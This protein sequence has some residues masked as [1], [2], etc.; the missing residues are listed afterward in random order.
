MAPGAAGIAIWHNFDAPETYSIVQTA[1]FFDVDIA[2]GLVTIVEELSANTPYEFMLELKDGTFTATRE[3]RFTTDQIE[4][5]KLVVLNTRRPASDEVIVT[6]GWRPVSGADRYTL[7]R[8]AGSETGEYISKYE[9]AG[10]AVDECALSGGV[11]GGNCNALADWLVF[12]EDDLTLGSVYYYRLDSCGDLGCAESD[13]LSLSVSSPPPPIFDSAPATSPDLELVTLL[14]GAS[15][16]AAIFEWD[17][18]LTSEVVEGRYTVVLSVS[19]N[20]DSGV[21]TTIYDEYDATVTLTNA[22]PYDYRLS[23]SSQGETGDYIEV[24]ESNPFGNARK[25]GYF[26]SDLTLGSVYYYRLSVCN[27]SGCADPSAVVMLPVNL[28]PPG[29][30]APELDVRRFDH[31]DVL[32]SQVITLDSGAT[33]VMFSVHSPAS[34]TVTLTWTQVDRSDKYRVFR[35]TLAAETDEAVIRY[36][37]GRIEYRLLKDLDY[38]EIYEGEGVS[39]HN[40][41]LAHIDAVSQDA[42]YYYQVEACDADDDCGDRSNFVRVGAPPRPLSQTPDGVPNLAITDIDVAVKGDALD[43]VSLTVAD[44]VL[45]WSEVSGAN[46]Y[47]LLRAQIG[48]GYEEIYRGLDLL[49]IESNARIGD[50]YFYRVQACNGLSCGASSEAV[51]LRLRRPGL[52]RILFDQSGSSREVVSAGGTVFALSSV[53]LAWEETPNAQYYYVLRG[54]AHG[55]DPFVTVSH[56][57]TLDGR[58]DTPLP[59][60]ATTYVENLHGDDVRHYRVQACNAFGCGD[61]SNTV[62]LGGG[63]LGIGDDGQWQDGSER[64]G[65]GRCDSHRGDCRFAD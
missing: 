21:S 20:M 38:V 18:L 31:G 47:R 59:V 24:H 54:G 60:F 23:R 2:T 64:R 50:I 1:S 46:N 7:S 45:E 58:A 29:L 65:R 17:V 41:R 37:D 43:V 55:D 40:D 6:L 10:E 35:A 42:V 3:F 9:G 53:T 5:G 36:G 28:D 14:H 16:P 52:A 19:V 56:P 34:L 8:A 63:L 26:D 27:G 44:A 62:A 22:L 33:S 57:A 32:V 48:G 61:A 49:F 13:I 11:V 15:S 39:I 12:T 4:K 51:T 30:D 25:L